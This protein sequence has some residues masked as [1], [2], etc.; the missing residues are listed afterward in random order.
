LRV[1]NLVFTIPEKGPL[2]ALNLKNGQVV[3]EYDPPQR[4]WDR[5]YS[6]NG[7]LI[8][9]GTEGG[10][11]IALDVSSGEVR[12]NEDLGINAQVPPVVT[13][14]V[15]YAATTFVGPGL[16]GDPNGRAILFSLDPTS[17]E[18]LWEFVSQSYILQ[19]PFCYD[20]TVYTGGSHSDLSVDVDEGGPMRIYALDVENGALKWTYEAEDGFVKAIYAS[21]NSAA[22]IAYQDFVNG[23][24]AETGVLLWRRDTGNWVPSI[25]GVGEVLYYGSANTVVQALA[26][27]T[28]ETLWEYNIPGASFNY[29]LGAPQR[30]LDDLYFLTQ[31][32]DIVAL[33][34]IDGTELWVMSTGITARVGLAVSGP[35]M[36]MGDQ[37]GV[38]YAYKSQ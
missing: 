10:R 32:G 37:D 3:W 30:V 17:G 4:I 15:L 9:V 27:D 25:S 6:S 14:E 20:G 11:L 22:Y 35:W 1:G 21:Q 8:L 5:A 38:V 18:L 19:T 13:D 24:A 26:M 33:N 31:R 16:E 28:G 36:F 23:L 29:M 2:L 7:E 34:A 12:W